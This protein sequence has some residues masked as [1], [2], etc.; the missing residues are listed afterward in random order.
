MVRKKYKSIFFDLDDTLW[1]TAAN[2]RDSFLEVYAHF[3]LG[4]FFRSFDHF[5][6]LYSVNNEQLWVDYAAGLISKEELND[7][8]FSHPLLQVGIDDPQLAQAY[9][10]YF[11]SIVPMKEKLVPSAREVLDE[12]ENRKYRLFVLSNGFR[13]LQDHKMRSADIHR[14]FE[15]VVLSD[16][17]GVLKPNPQL[18]Y[19]AMSATQ[20]DLNTSLMIG[21][22]FNTDI[23][24]ARNAGIDQVFFNPGRRKETSFKPTYEVENLKDVLHLLP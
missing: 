24:G 13:E 12:L 10:S 14:Y 19:F 20:S 15:K 16:D 11:F 8:R 1:D 18:F 2:A 17:I 23:A 7:R 9:S 4:R 21:D 3:H 22:N 6:S 5:Y